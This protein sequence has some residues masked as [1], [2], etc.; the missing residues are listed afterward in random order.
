[1]WILFTL[2]SLSFLIWKWG[3]YIILKKVPNVVAGTEQLL[4]TSANSHNNPSKLKWHYNSILLI[5]KC[6]MKIT[7][8]VLITTII[9]FWGTKQNYFK[10]TLCSYSS[11][12]VA[13]NLRY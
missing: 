10:H 9:I 3:D 8:I 12:A 1:M 5:V 2:L 11:I 13:W 6:F 7:I 4:V